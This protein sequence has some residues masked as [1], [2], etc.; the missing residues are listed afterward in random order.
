[1]AISIRS[2]VC[3]FPPTRVDLEDLFN[4]EGAELSEQLR[5]R[6][7]I[8]SVRL[9]RDETGSEL[10]LDAAREAL[11]RSGVTAAQL[12][13]IVD[14]T[15]LPQEYLVPAWSM[16]NKLQADLGAKKAYTLGFSGGG[17]SNFQVALSSAAA[18][19]DSDPG[20]STALLVGADVTIPGNRILNPSTPVTVM[21]DGA[22]ALVLTEGDDG[23]V[24]V[25]TK[26]RTVG[27]LHDVCYIR[28]GAM[29]YPDRADLYRLELDVERSRGA[30]AALTAL[31]GELLEQ[32]SLAVRDVDALATTNLSA[33]DQEAF[34]FGLGAEE[35][36]LVRSNLASHGHVQ[37]TDLVLNYLTA[38]A[39]NG[40]GGRLLLG[41]HG[42]GF[43]PAATLLKL[44]ERPS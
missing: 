40:N 19:I 1:V 21:G 7:G 11:E 41:S 15:I 3:R 9:C 37:G 2:A 26:A 18:L 29:A 28:G 10:A 12:D 44:S 4:E 30:S 36:S 33:E 22:S 16:G 8:D 5:A 25:A 42:M 34:V 27:G 31:C 17:A 23:D 20:V 24:V 38:R 35:G 6:L 32:R 43:M 14:Y 13:V 39:D